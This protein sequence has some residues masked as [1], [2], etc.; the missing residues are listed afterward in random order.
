MM[1]TMGKGQVQDRIHST[2]SP[3]TASLQDRTS[4]DKVKRIPDLIP[5]HQQLSSETSSDERN[6]WISLGKN[7]WQ[8]RNNP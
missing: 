2:I 5:A 7:P 4:S 6:E 1:M 8:Q 3:S